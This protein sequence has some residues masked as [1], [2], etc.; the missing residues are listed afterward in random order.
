MIAAVAGVMLALSG[1]AGPANEEPRPLAVAMPGG[2]TA[3]APATRPPAENDGTPGGDSAPTSSTPGAGAMTGSPGGDSSPVGE[4]PG[5][6]TRP[7]NT[8]R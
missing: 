5:G 4:S 2:D 1:A 7:S 6:S 3:T 8:S